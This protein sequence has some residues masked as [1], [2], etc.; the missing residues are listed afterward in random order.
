MENGITRVGSRR[1]HDNSSTDIASATLHQHVGISSTGIS[2]TMTFLAETEA[3][4]MKRILGLYQR[5]SIKYVT[6][7]QCAYVIVSPAVAGQFRSAAARRRTQ[8]IGGGAA[9]RGRP[10]TFFIRFTNKFRS[11]LKIVLGTFLVIKALRFADD[12]C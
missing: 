10:K 4:V 12:Q 3:G 1:Y 7:E 11:I 2:S 6:L 5:P 9:R 8:K